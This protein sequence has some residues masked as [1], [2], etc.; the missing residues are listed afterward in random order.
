MTKERILVW[1]NTLNLKVGV[2]VLVSVLLLFASLPDCSQ[3]KPLYL[4]HY[5]CYLNYNTTRVTKY[6]YI[7][8]LVQLPVLRI[9]T[10]HYGSQHTTPWGFQG[11]ST[12]Y[13]KTKYLLR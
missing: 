10:A 12:G 3:N 4:T 7:A 9:L 1:G 8:E 13:F 11:F 6:L 2:Y 5:V